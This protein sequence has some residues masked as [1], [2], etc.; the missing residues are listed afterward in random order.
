[1]ILFNKHLG[2]T[3][4]QALNR[5]RIE[6]SA[7]K[8]A[9]LSYAGRLDPMA[10]GL[11][12]ILVD[13]EC[14]NKEPYLGLDKEYEA[15]ILWG[16]ETDTH[17]LLGLV[18]NVSNTQPDQEK[19]ADAIKNLVGKLIQEYPAYSSKPVGGK[20][21]FAWAREGRIDEVKKPTK[22]I[23]IFKALS[24]DSYTMNNEALLK[25]IENSVG[26]VNGDFRQAEILLKWKSVLETKQTFGV[27]KV[28]IACSSGT[29]IR[30]LA[31]IL[32]AQIGTG[33]VLLSLKRIRIG[34][35]TLV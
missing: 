15:E 35:Y 28:T 27:S 16:V 12:L 20:S 4:L 5:L 8:D 32:G 3:P 2:E 19:I 29:Y 17:D 31:H 1:M 6:Q 22:Q 34:S 7:V 10:E 23:E 30:Q 33:A 9:V 25:Y 24:T 11:L 13:D 21:L 14:K 18:Q 26:K